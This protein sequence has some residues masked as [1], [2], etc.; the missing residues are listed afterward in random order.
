MASPPPH[1]CSSPKYS[2]KGGKTA[3]QEKSMEPILVPVA[4]GALGPRKLPWATLVKVISHFKQSIMDI[5]QSHMLSR[6]NPLAI[7]QKLSEK[8]KYPMP[9]KK[10]WGNHE[11]LS[12]IPFQILT[13][14]QQTV[15]SCHFC[16]DDTK[17][18]SSSFDYTVKLWDAEDGSVVRNF[19]HGPQ[20]PV[21]ECSVTADSRR[22]AAAA[23]DKSLRTWDL[24][25]GKLL[26]KISHESFISSCNF[27]PDGKYVVSGLDVDHGICITDARN[28]KT[29]SHLKDHH[30]KSVTRCCFDPDSQ[31]VASVS[32]DKSIKIWDVTSQ[33]TLLTITKAHTNAIS[34]CCFTFSGHF[35]CT[36]S[37]D[38]TLKIWNIHSGEFRNRGACVT[39]MQGHEGSVSSC[40][41]AR[42][43]S[44]LVSGG[45]DKSVSIWDVGE[46]YRKISLKGHDDWVM[47]VAM[48]NN[49][50]W[51]LS[52]SKD[53]TMRLW[54][55]EE[56]DQIPLVI[57]NKNAL[58]LKVK[59]CEECERPFSTYES[60]CFSE[61]VN[62]CMFCRTQEKDFSTENLSAPEK[63][64]PA[65]ECSLDKDH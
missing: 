52:A 8:H 1:T 42:D 24:E 64:S 26:W 39:L 7:D 33:A 13:G 36:S 5:R 20:A 4:D 65:M 21:L 17:L 23:Y 57:K 58:G 14:H 38:K 47:D 25:T 54:N 37:W 22:V 62:R 50:K 9:E 55:I 63:D 43:T 46:G 51:I 44:F 49:K 6:F 48:S 19:E 59:Q 56:I 40:H 12:K 28:A 15:S 60:D 61:M 35:L 27:S 29:V 53:K 2:D 18:L 16:V 41:F 30:K 45:F 10:F 32:L 11:P 34:N 3:P 31:K